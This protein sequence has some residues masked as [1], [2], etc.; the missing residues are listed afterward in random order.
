MKR[1][2]DVF[3][4]FLPS[5]GTGSIKVERAKPAEV[6]L[7]GMMTFGAVP[8]ISFWRKDDYL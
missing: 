7:L 1:G 5:R 3:L 8:S 6:A 2:L 4:M